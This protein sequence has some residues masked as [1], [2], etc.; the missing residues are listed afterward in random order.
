MVPKDTFDVVVT[1]VRPSKELDILYAYIRRRIITMEVPF[2]LEFRPMLAF[3]LPFAHPNP[4]ET[5]IVAL[6]EYFTWVIKSSKVAP[7]ARLALMSLL[8]F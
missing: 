2:V 6:P 1:R 8:C 4:I 3:I 5:T 7:K